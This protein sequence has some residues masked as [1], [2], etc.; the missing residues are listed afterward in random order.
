MR[1]LLEAALL[2]VNLMYTS[3]LLFMLVYWLSV[4]FGALDVHFLDFNLDAD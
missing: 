3:L 1:E 2:P 4:I